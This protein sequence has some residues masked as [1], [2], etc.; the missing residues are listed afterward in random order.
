LAILV[1]AMVSCIVCATAC[2]PARP[3]AT[4]TVAAGVDPCVR[5]PPMVGAA[6]LMRPLGGPRASLDLLALPGGKP[7]SE[8]LHL[9]PVRIDLSWARMPDDVVVMDGELASMWTT[10]RALST[11]RTTALRE[12]MFA[13]ERGPDCAAA[14]RRE[15]ARAEELR[16]RLT[17]S[18]SRLLDR[19]RPRA[20]RADAS[21]DELLA[22]ASL[23]EEEA[24]SMLDESSDRY[25]G[26]LERARVDFERAAHAPP[27]KSVLQF[28]AYYGLA[29]V[30]LNAASAQERT[31]LQAILAS[32][33][34]TM[35]LR[36]ETRLRLGDAL[37]ANEDCGGAAELFRL[38]AADAAHES[39]PYASTLRVIA[40]LRW[41]E[42]ELC[43]GHPRRAI[44]VA[45]QILDIAGDIDILKELATLIGLA[46]SRL[47]TPERAGLPA[48]PL[49]IFVGAAHALAEEADA[50]GDTPT[51]THARDAA[52]KHAPGVQPP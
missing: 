23:E 33:S 21:F 40:L 7:P 37:V 6:A 52:A 22:A 26:A 16:L 24:E 20:T 27:R 38:S 29:R 41:S 17:S 42:A 51:A 28:W 25:A 34:P 5:E 32:E 19:L 1:R 10:H 8:K 48:V 4:Q 12:R 2:S 36:I 49:P 31:A 46:I 47:E 15:S 44:E 43:L 3:H 9:E 11:L 35:L 45:V 13:S 50:R 39:T 18:R 14:V 30:A